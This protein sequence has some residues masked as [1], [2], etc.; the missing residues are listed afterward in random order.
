ML[1]DSELL[2]LMFCGNAIS[3]GPQRGAYACPPGFQPDLA[4]DNPDFIS[5]RTK[6]N[7]E[8]MRRVLALCSPSV[9]TE[10]SQNIGSYIPYVVR[11]NTKKHMQKLFPRIPMNADKFSFN[12]FYTWMLKNS[13]YAFDSQDNMADTVCK[14][15]HSAAD[16]GQTEADL[17]EA[18]EEVETM[19]AQRIN[20]F[21]GIMLGPQAETVAFTVAELKAFC[22]ERLHAAQKPKSLDWALDE[23]GSL[24]EFGPKTKVRPAKYKQALEKLLSPLVVGKKSRGKNRG[25]GGKGHPSRF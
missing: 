7:S 19:C 11:S 22:P 3:H 15:A 1:Q 17:A 16:R 25:K 23:K 24:D 9:R 8:M 14:A 12:V 10:V 21:A 20:T 18:V 13:P 2:E 5:A 6:Y 4:P